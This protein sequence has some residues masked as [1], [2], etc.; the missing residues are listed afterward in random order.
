MVLATLAGFGYA[1]AYASVRR[2]STDHRV[3]PWSTRRIS[4][5]PTPRL[6]RQKRMGS[7]FSLINCRL[8]GIGIRIGMP[9]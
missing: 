9:W 7:N 2:R 3:I 8:V 6:G 1:C 5:S 4:P